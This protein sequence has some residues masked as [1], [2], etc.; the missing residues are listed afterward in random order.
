MGTEFDIMDIAAAAAKLGHQVG[1]PDEESDI[2]TLRLPD[3]RR[4]Q[5]IGKERLHPGRAEARPGRRQPAQGP[6]TAGRRER[7]W[8][9][10]ARLRINAGRKAG[11]LPSDLVGAIANEAGMSS[12]AIGA[13]DIADCYSMVEVADK[14]ADQVSNALR[15]STLRGKKVTV[16]QLE[17]P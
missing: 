15:R 9:G 2:P 13:I 7:V 14:L 12:R 10:I 11:I 17:E 4:G 16:H 8:L 3:R 6:K 1:S 5:Q